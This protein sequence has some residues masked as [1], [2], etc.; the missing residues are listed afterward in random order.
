MSPFFILTMAA[1]P[2]A[3]ACI[4]AYER[5]MYD[6]RWLE[7]MWELEEQCDGVDITAGNPKHVLCV[8][9]HMAGIHNQH[10]CMII[11]DDL[12]DKCGCQSFRS[13]WAVDLG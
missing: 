8:C 11:S 5:D 3:I 2:F 13:V 4:N 10:G 12:E 6:R 7:R 1:L 9:G